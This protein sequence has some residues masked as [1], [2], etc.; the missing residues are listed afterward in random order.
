MVSEQ[1]LRI[2]QKRAFWRW[3]QRGL[4]IAFRVKASVWAVAKYL[5]Q[6]RRD[7]FAFNELSRRAFGQLAFVA[8]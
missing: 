6:I 8:I 3:R 1:H 4:K 2:Y 7:G 5:A